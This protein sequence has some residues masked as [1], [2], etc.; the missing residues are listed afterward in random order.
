M[1]PVRHSCVPS[2][3]MGGPDNVRISANIA[4]NSDGT[5]QNFHGD[6]KVKF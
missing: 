4:Q 3:L 6:N 5:G 2:G 1:M